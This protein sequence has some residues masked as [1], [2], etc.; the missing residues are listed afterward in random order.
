MQAEVVIPCFNEEKNLIKLISECVQAIE[1]SEHRL[2]FV[3]VN[4]GSTDNSSLV[5]DQFRSG[6]EGIKIFETENNLG[7]GGGILEGLKLTS[8]PIVG[9]THADLQTPIMDCLRALEFFNHKVELVKGRRVDRNILDKFFSLGM[10]F[11]ESVL[12]RIH[13]YEINAQPTL[14][15][16]NFYLTWN[17][18]PTDFSL[19]LFALLQAKRSIGLVIRFPVRFKKRQF[20]QSSWNVNWSSRF[21]FIKRTIKYSI[22]LRKD[23]K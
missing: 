1:K 8:S 12:F 9:W 14:I 20:G 23:V 3:I 4:N 6:I 16:R 10:G 17:E 15:S 11:F 18:P 2:G 5:L 7:Y 19:D 13:L 21:K 22:K